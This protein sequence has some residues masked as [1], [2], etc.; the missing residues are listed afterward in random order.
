VLP[1]E[2]LRVPLELVRHLPRPVGA[3]TGS[4][5]G[6]Q[7]LRKLRP[8]KVHNALSRRWFERRLDATRLHTGVPV[9]LLGSVYGGWLMPPDL[10]GPGWLCYTV[11]AGGDVSFDCELVRRFGARVRTF[12][13]VEAFVADALRE[14]EGDERFSAHH[15]AIATADGPLRMQVSHDPRSS[16]VSSAGLYESSS[17]VELPGRTLPSLMSELGDE[18]IDLLKLDVEGG[19]YEL[20]PTLSLRELGVKVF[21]IQLHHSGSI[22]QARALV[23]AVR[24]DGFEP[25]SCRHPVKL[26]FVR[27]DLLA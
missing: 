4:L 22:A 27:D 12:D 11:G 23:D 3:L 20:M 2:S 19:E 21:A 16:S 7:A 10:I 5:P 1:T 25:I 24:R 8:H 17:Y 6:A 13:A 14:A 18:R 15:A 26:T 9:E